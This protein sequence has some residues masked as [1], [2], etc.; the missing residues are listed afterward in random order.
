M[1]NLA[2]DKRLKKWER[3]MFRAEEMMT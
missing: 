1:N 2:R 3:A